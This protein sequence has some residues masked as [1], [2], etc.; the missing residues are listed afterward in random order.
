M[1]YNRLLSLF[2]GLFVSFC[3]GFLFF[4]LFDFGFYAALFVV[5]E[6]G[7][8]GGAFGFFFKSFVFFFEFEG[9]EVSF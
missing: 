4:V 5:V 3:F 1:R 6:C 7:G 2:E 9:P 8:F